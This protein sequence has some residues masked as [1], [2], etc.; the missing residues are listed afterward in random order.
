M[1]SLSPF[2]CRSEGCLQTS[3]T[4]YF[5]SQFISS[6]V[7]LELFTVGNTLCAV[8]NKMSMESE[9]IYIHKTVER[10][11]KRR[12]KLYTGLYRSSQVARKSSSP[13][14]A[15]ANFQNIEIRLE[16][17]R[18]HAA[19]FT[20]STEALTAPPFQLPLLRWIPRK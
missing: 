11:D 20:A 8:Y 3:L 17:A 19:S 6:Y 9:H 16:S 18:A 1:R 10:V 2:A 13:L 12:I 5:S 14:P 15:P 4:S 7:V